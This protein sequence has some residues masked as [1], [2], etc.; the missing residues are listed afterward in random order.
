MDAQIGSSGVSALMENN[1]AFEQNRLQRREVEL[2][3]KESIWREVEDAALRLSAMVQSADDAIIGKTIKG[4]V[5]TWNPGAGRLYGYPAA[6]MIGRDMKVLLPPERSDE[7]AQ[8][9]QRIGRGERVEH[10]DTVRMCKDG[11]LVHVS[12]AISPIRAKN[13]EVIAAS[14]VARDITQSAELE[15]T[16]ARLAYA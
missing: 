3:A 5:Q 11:R 1:W 13:G 7:E 9:L 16:R 12:I 2:E 15:L 14:H 6:E 10:F 4:I 8:I